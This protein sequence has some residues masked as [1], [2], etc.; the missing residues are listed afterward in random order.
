[1][2]PKDGWRSMESAPR[3]GQIILVRYQA[4]DATG[5]IYRV[6]TAM[7]LPDQEGENWGWRA[8]A[9]THWRPKADGWMYIT[10][11]SQAQEME[12]SAQPAFDL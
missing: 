4:F 11:F 10:D 3:D 7:W 9:P 2:I 6:Q 8:P 5:A 1:M 12:A